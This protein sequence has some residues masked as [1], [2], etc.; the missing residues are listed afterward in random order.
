[1]QQRTFIGRWYVTG[2]Q[3]IWSIRHDQNLERALAALVIE[4]DETADEILAVNPLTVDPRNEVEVVLRTAPQDLLNARGQPAD[5]SMIAIR[6]YRI[7]AASSDG[8]SLRERGLLRLLAE[9]HPEPEPDPAWGDLE[10]ARADRVAKI[11]AKIRGYITS[12]YPIEKQL[13][14]TIVLI[15]AIYEGRHNQV[16]AVMAIWDW[17]TQVIAYKYGVED[18]IKAAATIEEVQA[19]DLDFTPFDDLDPKISLQA[20]LALTD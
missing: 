15:R 5:Q 18:Q 10:R 12:R 16:A 17:A 20:T 3:R 14:F 9:G 1:M 2:D 7:A 19:L 6:L 11:D 8:L 13:S 4:G